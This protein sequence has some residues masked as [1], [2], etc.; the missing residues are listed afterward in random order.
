MKDGKTPK[1]LRARELGVS[2]GAL[3]YKPIK[4][5]KDWQLKCDIEGALREHPSYGSRRL[6]SRLRLSRKR[7]RR[8]M[9]LFGLRPYR[10]RVRNWRKI[11]IM[12]KYPNLLLNAFPSYQN[13]IWVSDFTR[14]AFKKKAVYVATVMD[15][16]TRKI[17]GLSVL[18]NHAVQLTLSAFLSSLQNY[19]RPVIFHSDNGREYDSE[20]FISALE[21]LGIWISRSKPGCP[22]ENGYQESFYSQ[23][24]I[25]LG[26]PNRFETL[27]ELVY[28]I[29]Q[30][31]Y[32]YNHNRIHSAFNM[33]PE[34]FALQSGAGYNIFEYKVGV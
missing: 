28:A 3:Y 33:P 15:V 31:I 14:L 9:N 8:V 16:F 13:H 2:R 20:I 18:T 32:D 7:V 5:N 27:G 26:D 19:P 34:K 4:P 6:A 10:R 17:V 21:T 12:G 24:K 30:T 11:K 1:A 29:Y 23:F 25:D 22:W